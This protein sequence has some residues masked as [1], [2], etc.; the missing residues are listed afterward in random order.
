MIDCTFTLTPEQ[1]DQAK[2]AAANCP[3]C[4]SEPRLVED[5]TRNSF[6]FECANHNC[7]VSP[8]FS[9]SFQQALSTWNSR[10]T[11]GF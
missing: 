4:N 11:N 10:F 1:I 8:G 2:K 3:F 6:W 9:C 5:E 7:G